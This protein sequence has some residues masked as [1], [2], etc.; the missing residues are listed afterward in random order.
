MT[1]IIGI[2]PDLEASGLAWVRDGNLINLEKRGFL[3]LQALIRAQH[4]VRWVLEDVEAH[5]PTFQRK[6]AGQAAMRKVAQNVG[7]VK[8]VA[9]LIEQTLVAAGA[10]YVKVRPLTG[11]NKRRAKNDAAF[12][13]QLT[14]WQ[15]S[16]NQ[17]TRDA[18]LLAL[19]GKAG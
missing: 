14:G 13:N 6:G 3:D 10:D 8:A 12:F 9:R 17:D 5:R 4:G 7:Q 16:S 2:D 15:K 1:V 19:Y 11:T 18:A